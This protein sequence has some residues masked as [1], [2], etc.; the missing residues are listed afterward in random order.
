M[1]L[2]WLQSS[3][4]NRRPEVNPRRD[5]LAVLLVGLILLVAV[6]GWRAY[7]MVIFQAEFENLTN[8]DSVAKTINENRLSQLTEV[9][10]GRAERLEELKTGSST[11]VQ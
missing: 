10:K 7:E 2:S 4:F 6:I 3:N 9:I 1:K 8:P 11:L 5:W